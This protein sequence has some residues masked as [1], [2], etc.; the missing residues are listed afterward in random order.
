MPSFHVLI[1]TS[2]RPS[3]QNML[4]SLIPQLH[5]CDHITI[6]FDG[7]GNIPLDISGAL[8]QIHIKEQLPALGFWGHG[9][10]NKT[11]LERTDFVLHADDDDRYEEGAFAKLRNLC[12]RV[13]SLYIAQFKRQ[14]GDLVPPFTGLIREN[15]I[16]TPC[17]I[18]PYDLNAWA[19]KEGKW[20]LRRG[21]DGKFYEA[22]AKRA[23]SIKELEIVIYLIG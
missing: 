15:F 4:Y 20:L 13:D 18:I 22:I 5:A 3:L 8:C 17:G 19:A 11:I 10:R 23:K 21:G 2:G 16:G 6:V 1:A 12:K 14:N 9:I 7:I